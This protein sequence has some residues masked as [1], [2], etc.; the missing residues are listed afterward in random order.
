VGEQRGR[1]ARRCGR[2]TCAR[3]EQALLG[4]GATSEV[5]AGTMERSSN[6]IGATESRQHDEEGRGSDGRR[7]VQPKE[8]EAEAI[9]QQWGAATARTRAGGRVAIRARPAT[10]G[11]GWRSRSGTRRRVSASGNAVTVGR[12]DGVG[13]GDPHRPCSCAKV[14]SREGP[15]MR[16]RRRCGGWRRRGPFSVQERGGGRGR[17]RATGG[18][19]PVMRRGGGF[20]TWIEGGRRRE[21]MAYEARCPDLDP[22]GGEEEEERGDRA[23]GSGDEW[24]GNC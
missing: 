8:W 21:A 6:A 12:E 19:A 1:R 5:A 15:E 10:V 22:I 2:L 13:R 16:F 9:R 23:G 24:G 3:A 18:A 4:T 14:C 11:A 17:R 20:L 7:G